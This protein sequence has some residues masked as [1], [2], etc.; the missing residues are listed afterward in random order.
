[1]DTPQG[2]HRMKLAEEIIIEWNESRVGE[3]GQAELF[4]VDAKRVAG[5]WSFTERSTWEEQWYP[6][7]PAILTKFAEFAWNEWR[8]GAIDP[9]TE[10]HVIG[11]GDSE[12][13]R[14]R[15]AEPG[16]NK[17]RKTKILRRIM[18]RAVRITVDFSRARESERAY[19]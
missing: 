19:A 18:F 4:F 12:P 11:A 2:R 15:A 8:N 9:A 14:I 10:Y 6:G 1:M 16:E 17:S 7:S 13:Y 5:K 3:D